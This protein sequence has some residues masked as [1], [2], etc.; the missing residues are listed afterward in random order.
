M[1]QLLVKADYHLQING[2]RGFESGFP[3]K[4]GTA[5]LEAITSK[6]AEGGGDVFKALGGHKT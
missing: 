2:K 4:G 3:K 5:P 6:G 1:F